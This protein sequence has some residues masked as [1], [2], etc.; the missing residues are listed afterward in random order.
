MGKLGSM[1]GMPIKMDRTT[2]EK[3]AI[4]YARVLIEMPL[5]G[6]F[7]EYIVFVNDWEVLVRQKVH[8][9]RKLILCSHCKMLEYEEQ[10]CREKNKVRQEWRPIDRNKD[11]DKEEE[12][13]TQG[14]GNQGLRIQED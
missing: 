7:P 8:Y 6:S 10:V 9:E 4:R 3:T 2:T 12:D 11:G 13:N 5:E 1:L 14:G